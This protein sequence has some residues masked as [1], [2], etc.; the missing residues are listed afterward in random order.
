M[1]FS[2]STL[3]LICY[4][5]VAMKSYTHPLPRALRHVRGQVNEI[6]ERYV[7]GSWSKPTPDADQQHREQWIM[8]KYKHRRVVHLLKFTECVLF[9][10]LSILQIT[11]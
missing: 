9:F 1:V 2:N 10:F 8:A 4:V 7:P 5:P 6:Y 11:V 3:Q